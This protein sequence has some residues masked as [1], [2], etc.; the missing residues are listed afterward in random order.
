[1]RLPSSPLPLRLAA[2]V[3][4]ALLPGAAVA[5]RRRLPAPTAATQIPTFTVKGRVV[6]D[7]SD[8]PVRRTQIG[9]FQLPSS[10]STERTS[11]TDR[12]GRFV[13]E[14]V[15]T[16]AYF[17]MVN[18][19]GIIS[20]LA[21]MTLTD[22]GPSENFDLKSIREYCTEI[23]VDGSNVNVTVHARRGG[24]VSGKVTYSDGEPAIDVQVAVIRPNGKKSARVLTGINAAALM[25]LRTDDRGRYRVAGLPPGEYIVSAAEANTSQ[26][27]RRGPDAFFSGLFGSDALLVTYY[28]G[29]SL[30]DDAIKL[31]VT[32]G[33]ETSDIDIT[34]LD[35]TPHTVRG[36][37]IAKLDRVPLAGATL[38]VRLPDM[39][40]WFGGD[41]QQISTDSEGI[42]VLD[43]VPDGTYVL[44]VEPPSGFPVPGADPNSDITFDDD[45]LPLQKN[46]PT[47]KFVR[48]EIEI[49]V[50][51]GDLVVEPIALAEGASISGNVEWPQKADDNSR[52]YAQITWRYEGESNES[53]N[54]STGTS[55][56]EFAVEGIRAG[57][58]YLNANPGY[59]G[60]STDND[61]YVKSITLNGV[62]LRQ[63]PL[64]ISEGQSIKNVRIVIA[65]NPAKGGVKLTDAEGKPVPAKRVA[66]I[67]ADEGRWLF[68]NDTVTG[69]TDTR[70]MFTFTAAPGDYLVII[71]APDDF[72]PPTPEIIRQ[73]AA[74]AAHIKLNS[75][76]NQPVAVILP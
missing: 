20:P 9:L 65:Q 22:K 33:S 7:D 60:G 76:D 43:G 25:S 51:G 36:S 64:T 55:G 34:L 39:A 24:A 17:A 63:K 13:I 73:R 21:F 62:D 68:A 50:S 66:I 48:R 58:V 4:L 70:G 5:Q 2:V 44:S 72:W 37:V 74:T 30:R 10:R 59:G 1:M 29:G 49:T 38:S 31:E 75:G 71:A 18:S 35:S 46:V 3:L 32:A 45:G 11:V 40:T 27:S 47:R 16:G 52:Q 12:D 23:I 26:N 56:D 57:K 42:W 8:R 19:P 6:F 14:D 28:G 41:A 53:Y 67:P 61:L 54:N 15:P 69:T